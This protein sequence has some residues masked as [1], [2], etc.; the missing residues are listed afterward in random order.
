MTELESSE[1]DECPEVEL[2]CG[3]GRW[4]AVRE[5]TILGDCSLQGRSSD[6]A[7]QAG[8]F[9]LS[10][11]LS[12]SLSLYSLHGVSSRK[13]STSESSLPRRSSSSS[14]ITISLHLSILPLQP[15]SLLLSPPF[16]SFLLLPPSLPLPPAP[17]RPLCLVLQ[18][19]GLSAVPASLSAARPVTKL[20]PHT[21]FLS[22]RV[23]RPP[24]RATAAAALVL[25]P[26]VR[27]SRR[28]CHISPRPRPPCPLPPPLGRRS[29]TARRR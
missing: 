21:I 26:T 14:S 7:I 3:G 5:T 4:G 20:S 13:S 8:W 15:P 1:R 24:A 22:R 10:V 27:S 29:L 9:C 18:S 19:A 16:S 6:S 28:F 25:P 23:T 11:C 12:V 17:P 2:G